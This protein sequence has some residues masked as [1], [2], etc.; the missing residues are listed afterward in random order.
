MKIRLLPIASICFALFLN[1]LAL[2][3]DLGKTVQ[4]FEKASEEV[5][6]VSPNGENGQ[7]LID[8]LRCNVF[9][10]RESGKA[11]SISYIPVGRDITDEEI[12][13]YLKMNDDAGAGWGEPEVRMKDIYGG[14]LYTRIVNF[15]VVPLGMPRLLSRRR[16]ARVHP[17]R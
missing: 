11:T 2:A 17:F 5:L 10:D 12:Q 15:L 6:L 8:G 4:D 13:K 14:H 16:R 7:F 3:D 9:F 1:A